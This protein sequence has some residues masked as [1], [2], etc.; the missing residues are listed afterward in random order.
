MNIGKSSSAVGSQAMKHRNFDFGRVHALERT[1]RRARNG[2]NH[3]DVRRYVIP[4]GKVCIVQTSSLTDDE[5]AM[6]AVHII[7]CAVKV[8]VAQKILII[9]RARQK[10]MIGDD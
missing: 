4:S 6:E 2:E 7:V 8:K 1:Y 9:V 10:T 5:G 3:T